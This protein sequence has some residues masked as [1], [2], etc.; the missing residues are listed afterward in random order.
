MTSSLPAWDLHV[1]ATAAVSSFAHFLCCMHLARGVVA[2]RFPEKGAGSLVCLKAFPHR[3]MLQ[4]HMRLC[5]MPLCSMR[6]YSKLLCG[7][8][9]S[10]IDCLVCCLCSAFH[11]E[12]VGKKKKT[13]SHS[14][15]VAPILLKREP[16]GLLILRLLWS[17]QFC[18]LCV[19]ISL[20]F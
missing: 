10:G 13:S 1:D 18:K 19:V 17:L 6:L 14:N 7:Q 15:D 20:S 12:P 11:A 8:G 4:S 2:C 16:I 9:F 5:S 3:R